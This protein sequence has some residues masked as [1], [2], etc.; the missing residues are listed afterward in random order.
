MKPLGIYVHIPYCLKKC[1][2]CDFVSFPKERKLSLSPDDY[3]YRV[4]REIEDTPEDIRKGYTV[5]SIYFGGGTPTCIGTDMIGR[6]L[7]AIKKNF[8]VPEDAEISIEANPETITE[9]KAE[10]LKALGF[11]RISMGVQ[12]LD[13]KVLEKLGRVH[14]AAKALEAYGIL[15]K[16]GFENINLDLML[17]VPE[18]TKDIW[19]DSLDK[20][21]ALGPEHISF[22]SLQIEDETPFYESYRKGDLEIPAWEENREMYSYALE[23][24]KRAGYIHYE[25]SNASK[26]GFECRH[27][28]KY[29]TMEDY[30]G[31]GTSAHSFMKGKRFYNTDDLEYV[32]RYEETDEEDEI[33]DRIGDFV[34]TQLRL[35]SGIDLEKF[36][37]LF[38]RDFEDVF[39]EL[40][41]DPDL[42]PY[43]DIQRDND[44]KLAGLALSRLGL[45]NTNKV[46][47]RF[48]R[49]IYL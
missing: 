35:I 6:I 31:F 17:G 15:R 26:P 28:L 1:S 13:D 44:G 30:L 11:N 22:Y 19:K 29:W 46:M 8:E 7:L 20:V 10:N 49:A 14:D 25:I 36:R 39:G 9:K 24:L 5:D 45:D 23:A 16:S 2:Y 41:K 21:V 18:Q 4:C 42:L 37:V 33:K 27:N 12:S 34:F 43:L 47:E 32:R 3:A 40:L 48:I 38:G